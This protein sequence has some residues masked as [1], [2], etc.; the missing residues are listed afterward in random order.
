MKKFLVLIVLALTFLT[1]CKKD[2]PEPGS[3][4]ITP[5]EINGLI[6][7]WEN[8][9]HF[10]YYKTLDTTFSDTDPFVMMDF[11]FIDL[12]NLTKHYRSGASPSTH[13]Y[14]TIENRIEIMT[15]TFMVTYKL[16]LFGDDSMT[17]SSIPRP[18]GGIP[19][20][21]SDKESWVFVKQ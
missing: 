17:L 18:A 8:Y 10:R 1:Q 21:G 7:Y 19:F 6:G 12:E 15:G 11:E 2:V 16:E 14:D 3:I 5:V 13:T 4:G 9:N 20:P